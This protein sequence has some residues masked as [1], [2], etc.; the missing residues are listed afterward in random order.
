[1]TNL[2]AGLG[3][4]NGDSKQSADSG[5]G[6][7]GG[8]LL[9][10]LNP[11]Q[12]EAVTM[13]PAPVLVVAGAGSGKTRVLT[14]RLAHLILEQGASPFQVLAITFT[15]KA[16]A[17]MKDRVADLVGPVARRMW[18]S[19][20]H[21]ACSRILRRESQL[22]GYRSAFSIYDQS[23]AVRL[24]DYVRRDL[25]LDPKRF[26]A[27]SVH[28]RI[29]ALKN[30]LILPEQYAEMAFGPHEQRIAKIY[31]EYQ[32]RLQDANAVDFDDMLVLAVRLFREHESAL[33]RWRD[34]FRHVLVDE[35]QDTNIAQWELVRMLT[36]EHRSVMAVGDMDQSI[37]KFRGA[38]F[39][40]LLRF[41]DAFPDAS[42]IVLDQ[43]YRSTQNILD[44]ANAV[45]ANNP[46]HRPKRLWSDKGIG[47]QIVRYQAEDEHDEASFVLGQI[48]SLIDDGSHRHGDMAI[49]YRTNAQSR[50]VEEALVRAGVPYRVFGGV[51]FYDRREIKDA[52][53][54]LRALANSDDE[55]S[56]KRIANTPKRGVGDTSLAKVEAYAQSH[57]TSFR[58][59]MLHAG[60][61]GV[62][63]KA[64]GGIRD[65][66][67]LLDDI[68]RDC[69]DGGVAD[70]LEAVLSRT[71]YIA[72]LEAERSI[73]SQGRIENL[74]ELVGVA[75]EFDEQVDAGQLTGLV[76]IGGVG[77]GEPGEGGGAVDTPY[78]LDR[79]QA[80]L[81]AVSLVTD[82]DNGDGEQSSVTLMTLHSAKG[83]E[84]PVVFL[85]GMEDGV[86]PHFRSLSEPEELEEERR[87]C[88]VGITRA[89]E[90][91]YLCHAWSRMLFGAT[92]YH[93]PS[94]FLEEIPSE[95]VN[96]VGGK[97]RRSRTEQGL[98]GRRESLVTTAARRESGG[99]IARPAAP[100]TSGADNLG[101][102]V[103]DDVMH[104]TYGEGVILSIRGQ[105]EKAEAVVH[106]KDVGDK[107]LLLAWAPLT[108]A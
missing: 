85:L 108:R 103:G 8:D 35:F 57:S 102:A 70:V 15:N 41:E 28:G 69:A 39:R 93:P 36:E 62:S 78:G 64:L 86:F 26:P 33:M 18:V 87:L 25:D 38:D 104:G 91:L 14:R 52:L 60:A 94:R 53:A 100:S 30:E 37:Y 97:K 42:V 107:T 68:E 21:S 74:Q 13:P 106:F 66:L 23:D 17:E 51:K 9:V 88:Y 40:N 95:L 101:L 19:T 63:G 50:V 31:A 76:A 82:M 27:R 65:L 46:S 79:V 22:L 11:A 12:L 55:V 56:W 84:F 67:D 48:R 90:R 59:G 80:F 58:D 2:L 73:E 29:S 49:F 20:F 16:A 4:D 83:L 6:G 89:Q 10:D 24:V 71:G 45:I 98:G 34:H 7:F 77:L 105:G 5:R 92:D 44:A 99:G 75:R 32:R 47:E 81:E 72:E 96:P 61:A 43:N 3:P 54:Y 1:M